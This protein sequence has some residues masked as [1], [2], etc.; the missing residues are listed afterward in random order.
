M[1]YL[2]PIALVL[3]CLALTLMLTFIIAHVKG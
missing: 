1:V 2:L 3:F